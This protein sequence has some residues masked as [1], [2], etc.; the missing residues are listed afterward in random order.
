M[1]KPR[2]SVKRPRYFRFQ[3]TLGGRHFIT[4][5]NMQTTSGLSIFIQGVTSLPDETWC[6]KKV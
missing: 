5:L 2:L 1:T 4:L 6:D 3:A